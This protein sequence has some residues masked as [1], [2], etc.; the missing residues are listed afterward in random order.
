VRPAE[1]FF[2]IVHHVSCIK[3]STVGGFT[4]MI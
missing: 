1:I 2:I 4:W 3:D